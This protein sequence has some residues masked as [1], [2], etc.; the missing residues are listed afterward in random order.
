MDELE[1]N[2]CGGNQK[3]FRNSVGDPK[4]KKSIGK[5]AGRFGVD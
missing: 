5:C 1:S 3:R 4:R 2:T